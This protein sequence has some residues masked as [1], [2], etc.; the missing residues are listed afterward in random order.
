MSA[1]N[2]AITTL[3]VIAVSADQVTSL[4]LISTPAK[5]MKEILRLVLTV[6]LI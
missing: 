5:V 4:T 2:S 3:E 6:M 1:P